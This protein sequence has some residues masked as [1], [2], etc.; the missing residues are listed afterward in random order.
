MVQGA[1][2][3]ISNGT[4]AYTK[5][6]H[7]LFHGN[8]WLQLFNLAAD[9]QLWKPLMDKETSTVPDFIYPYR[10]SNDLITTASNVSRHPW[11][12]MFVFQLLASCNL[13]FLTFRLF[14]FVPA[15]TY[16]YHFTVLIVILYYCKNLR[17]LYGQRRLWLS[18]KCSIINDSWY[19]C[20]LKHVMLMKYFILF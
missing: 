20:A 18:T 1:N 19:I 15:S 3:A 4:I 2:V 8:C 10:I 7:F 6:Y 13:S 16:C 5:R 14:C 17:Q 9:H 12:R 11:Y